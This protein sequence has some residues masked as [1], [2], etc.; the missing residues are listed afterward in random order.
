MFGILDIF[1]ILAFLSTIAVTIMT[2]T[3]TGPEGA[4]GIGLVLLFP[5]LV[6]AI[7]VFVMVGKELLNFIPGGGPVQF[8]IALGILI[9]FSIAIFGTIDRL[10]YNWAIQGLVITVPSLILVGCT[11]IIHQTDFPNLRLIYWVAAILLGTAAL[12]GWGL[13]GKSVYLYMQHEMEQSAIRAQKEREQIDERE[14]WEVAEYAKLDDSASLY[15]LLQL[16]WS[17]TEQIRQQVHERLRNYPQL[18]EKLIELLDKDNDQAISYVAKLYDNPPAKLAPAWGR[19]L[20]RQL[21]KWDNLQYDEHA[22]IWEY[23]LKPYFVGAQKLQLAGGSFHNELLAWYEHLMKCK[24]L[25]NLVAFVKNLLET[26]SK[27]E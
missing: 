21:K 20:K 10:Y 3:P 12:T 8:V 26:K 22:G 24:G 2:Q 13:A 18:D 1:L 5:C 19:M 14:Q 27:S 16:M 6:V 7:L 23:N 11:V 9:T 4:M 25:G 17:R 15:A